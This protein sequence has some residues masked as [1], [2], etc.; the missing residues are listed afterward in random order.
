MP[1]GSGVVAE[2]LML[3]SLPWVDAATT[4]AVGACGTVGRL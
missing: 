3:L 4:A 2:R 1:P